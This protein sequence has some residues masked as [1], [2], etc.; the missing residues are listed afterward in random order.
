M[1]PTCNETILESVLWSISSGLWWSSHSCQWEKLLTPNLCYL[2]TE[3]ATDFFFPSWSQSCWKCS[4]TC[5]L[6]HSFPLTLA[7]RL[8]DPLGFLPWLVHPFLAFCLWSSLVN[9]MCLQTCAENLLCAFVLTLTNMTFAPALQKI[10]ESWLNEWSWK[11]LLLIDADDPLSTCAC[12]NWAWDI[13]SADWAD[14]Q[15]RL[16]LITCDDCYKQHMGGSFM[17][18]W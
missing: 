5:L 9:L 3:H 4:Y 17:I 15:I 10:Q 18:K 14:L 8:V 7:P 12:S 16:R 1:L 11:L 2:T 6:L 13:C